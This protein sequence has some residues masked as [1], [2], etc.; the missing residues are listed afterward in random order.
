MALLK[1][2]KIELQIDDIATLRG[3]WPTTT[4]FFI[5]ATAKSYRLPMTE[6]HKI[7]W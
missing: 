6:V 3:T 5:I 7:I 2:V 1:F 4:S